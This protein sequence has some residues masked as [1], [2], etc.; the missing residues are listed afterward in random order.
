MWLNKGIRFHHVEWAAFFLIEVL[1]K[2]KCILVAT[3]CNHCYDFELLQH[4]FPYCL[5]L[6]TYFL[7]RVH[8]TIIDTRYSWHPVLL[9]YMLDRECTGSYLHSHCTLTWRIH[10]HPQHPLGLHSGQG[11]VLTEVLLH[12]EVIHT[13]CYYL[14]LHHLK[15]NSSGVKLVWCWHLKCMQG[16]HQRNNL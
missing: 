16:N 8:V 13:E 14:C 5:C 6:E 2:R 12:R 10:R 9:S 4:P 7:E 15:L 11:R 3:T 1:Q